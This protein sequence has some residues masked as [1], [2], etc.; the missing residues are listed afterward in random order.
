[1]SLTWYGSNG[2]FP[3]FQFRRLVTPIKREVPADAEIVTAFTNGQVTLRSN[4][5]KIGYHEA[6][7]LSSFQGVEVGD[8][9]VHG[10]DI[11]RGSVGVSD[12]TGAISAVC[13]VSLPN[14]DVSGRFVAYAI[15]AQAESGFTRAL[16]RGIREGG[17]DFRRWDTLAE[18]PIPKPPIEE[19]R[20]IA[21]FLDDQVG[22]IDQAIEMRQGQSSRAR[23]EIERRI[24]S[25]VTGK[26]S[27]GEFYAARRTP[28]VEAVPSHWEEIP[29]RFICTVTTGSG[30]TQDSVD[31][32]EFPFYVRS[33]IP[34][35][36]N[37]F[38]FNCEAVLTS[39]DG[40][41]VGKIFHLVDGR[42]HA[43]QRVY[44]LKDFKRVRADYFFYYFS[45]YFKKMALDGSAKSTVDSVR[46]DMI[47]G[48]PILV[49][50]LD[51]QERLVEVLRDVSSRHD[52]FMQLQNDCIALLED[53]KRSLITAAVTGQLDVTSARPIN[54]GAWVPNVG[55]ESPEHSAPAVGMGGI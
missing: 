41:G 10:L 8:L 45:A 30:D 49:P 36:S 1:M 21:D 39:G 27:S 22:R 42:F 14:P 48:M 23:E 34:H 55:V 31:E 50:P 43:H 17:A 7:D 6:T 24:E 5:D 13:N 3:E 15:R 53:R 19:Q 28:W 18:L 54:V 46:R 47:T 12:S 11:L 2:R 52:E 44:V 29:A 25:L 37:T 38:T 26:L 51:E 32:A 16:A 40:A 9:V 35:R 33:D 4:R 20:R